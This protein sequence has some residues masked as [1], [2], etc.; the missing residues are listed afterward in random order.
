MSELIVADWG[1][2]SSHAVR[3]ISPKHSSAHKHCVGLELATLPEISEISDST[4]PTCLL[5]FTSDLDTSKL[6]THKVVGI[7]RPACGGF[8]NS[9]F[10]HIAY[11]DTPLG[12]VKSVTISGVSL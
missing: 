2:S 12:T 1:T 6:K 10:I 8:E 7:P 4:C 11:S 3:E 5:Q 9:N